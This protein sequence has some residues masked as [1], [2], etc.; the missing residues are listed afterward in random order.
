MWF[1]G[2]E[3]MHKNKHYHRCIA[4]IKTT[5]PWQKFANLCGYVVGQWTLV[6][7]GFALSFPAGS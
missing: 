2:D 4:L 5:N 3:S 6:S 1:A 7:C